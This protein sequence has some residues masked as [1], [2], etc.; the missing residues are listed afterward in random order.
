M[1][2]RGKYDFTAT[3]DDELSFRKGDILKVCVWLDCD[4]II[5]LFEFFLIPLYDITS[6]SASGQIL[7]LQDEWCKAEMNGQEGFVPKNYIEMQTPGW[8]TLINV[9]QYYGIITNTVRHWENYCY[10]GT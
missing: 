1:E 7:S 2:A 6:L 9:C 4:M 3:A 8:E 5:K 10:T